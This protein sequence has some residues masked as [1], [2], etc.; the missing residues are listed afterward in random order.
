MTRAKTMTVPADLRTRLADE[1]AAI[2]VPVE[3]VLRACIVVALR[4]DAGAAAVADLAEVMREA[5]W[6]EPRGG[7]R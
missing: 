3:W 5:E 7:A 2:G 6:R 1:A 4:D